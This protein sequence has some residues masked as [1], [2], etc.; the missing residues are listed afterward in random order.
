MKLC[1]I[2]ALAA[3]PAAGQVGSTAVFT[4]FE[5]APDGL[6][7]EAMEGEVASI[8]EPSGLHME[9]RELTGI[10][11]AEVFT[12][13]A[14][15]KFVG[16]CNP[17]GV[18]TG[19]RDVGALGWSHISD[20]EVLP[21]ADVDCDRLRVFLRKDLAARD[22]RDRDRIFGRALGRVLAH[23]LLHIFAR[24]KAHTSRE[25]DRAYYSEHQLLSDN[26]NA[27]AR[28]AHIV[29]T[30]PPAV[31][32]STRG[33]S[34]AWQRNGCAQC[35]GPSGKGTRRGPPVHTAKEM[36]D[37]VVLA[38]RMERVAPAMIRRARN[39]KLPAPTVPEGDL[40]ELVRLLN[41]F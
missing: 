15:A 7:L 13:L 34:T 30:G 35:H 21:F 12:D 5:H 39:L 36:L 29:K 6:V 10:R 20:G 23:E 18:T 9:W 41:A 38:T 31:P 24:E 27:E 22:P 14:V 3:L 16:H 37:T 17:S 26:F 4:Q 40:P 28:E 2:L 19:S 8:M 1:L 25:V 11:A 33:K 32:V